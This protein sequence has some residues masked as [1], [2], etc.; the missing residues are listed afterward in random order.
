MAAGKLA[1]S[2]RINGR[3]TRNYVHRYFWDYAKTK[4][5]AAS[6][7]K[8]ELPRGSKGR[9]RSLSQADRGSG[10]DDEE[11]LCVASFIAIFADS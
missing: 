4:I 5:L 7:R 6:L 3:V 11:N 8:A 1:G 9:R 2:E 10:S